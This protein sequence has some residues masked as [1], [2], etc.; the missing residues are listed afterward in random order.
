MDNILHFNCRG[1]VCKRQ[2]N[3][4]LG[5][6]KK[7]TP[8]PYTALCGKTCTGWTK[9]LDTGYCYLKQ[10]VAASAATTAAPFC[11]SG[12]TSSLDKAF[13]AYVKSPL[14]NAGKDL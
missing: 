8:A 2:D 14:E 11:S 6:L 9:S 13:Q 10:T 12:G 3:A 5:P 4:Q 1:F 7:A